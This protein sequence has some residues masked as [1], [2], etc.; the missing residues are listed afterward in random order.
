MA[1]TLPCFSFCSKLTPG[2]ISSTPRALPTLQVLYLQ[3]REFFW[4]LGV[5]PLLYFAIW[6]PMLHLLHSL[7]EK[8]GQP[9]T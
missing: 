6:W 4:A 9:K 2:V 5:K 3:L 7:E 1:L 8:V